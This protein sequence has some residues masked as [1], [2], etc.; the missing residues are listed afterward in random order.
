VTQQPS[1]WHGQRPP[2]TIVVAQSGGPV[3]SPLAEGRRFELSIGESPTGF[4]LLIIDWADESSVESEHATL[5]AAREHA[6][7]AVADRALNWDEWTPPEE[8]GA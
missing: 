7:N 6:A 1:G 8:E 3:A 5:D 4:R 2:R